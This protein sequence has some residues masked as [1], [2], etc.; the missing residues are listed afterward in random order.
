MNPASYP[1]RRVLDLQ[2]LPGNSFSAESVPDADR[3]VIFGG[4]LLGQMIAAV[5]AVE[6]VG[7]GKAV[8]SVHAVFARAGDIRRPMEIAVDPIHQGRTL[9]SYSVSIAQGERAIC[10]GLVLTDAG[11]ADL[12]ITTQSMPNVPAPETLSPPTYQSSEGA[13]L[14]FVGNVDVG[15][16]AANG[17]AELQV[18]ARWDD[19]GSDVQSVHQAL[20]AWWTDPFL[21]PAAMRPEPGLALSMAHADISTGVLAHTITFHQELDASKWLLVTQRTVQGGAGRGFGEGAVFTREGL[22]VAS[23]SQ[24]FM[25]RRF[26]HHAGSSVAAM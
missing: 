22:L 19:P 24:E 8:R 18:W 20:A 26:A 13:E 17:P 23:F 21:I 4:Q 3:P 7:A 25:I 12:I 6:P 11:D 5:D 10:R 15:V 14:R 9:S 16:A 2:R 1:A